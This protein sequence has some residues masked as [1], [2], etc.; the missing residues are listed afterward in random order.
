M[1]SDESQIML[2]RG[3]TD[4]AGTRHALAVLRM[5]DGRAED[6][7]AA[8]S[9][10]APD[11]RDTSALLAALLD[12]LGGYADVTPELAAAL[13]RSDRDRLV[14]ELRRSLFGAHIQLATRCENPACR[15]EV[16][17]D[18]EIDDLLPAPAARPELTEVR[19]SEGSV[20][21]RPLTGADDA[22]AADIWPVLSV[23]GDW[24][25]LGDAAR[26]EAALALDAADP[27]VRRDIEVACPDCRLPIALYLD[28]TEL[29][30]RELALGASRLLA[31]VHVLAFH[32]GW[33]EAEILALPRPRRW[34]YLA[35]I[36]AQVTGGSL[37]DGW[38]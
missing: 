12:R 34:R 2:D 22:A 27:G 38:R 24:S 8:L 19:T 3:L 13:P 29:L 21:L 16:D 30:V 32:Y 9:L 11:E 37:D 5:P 10:R 17:L 4:T 26:Q 23:E 25:A 15:Q 20:T 35:L 18:L 14:L 7:M 33:R 1:F 36:S 28:P 31:E 6:A